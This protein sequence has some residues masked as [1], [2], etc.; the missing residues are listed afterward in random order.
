MW[1]GYRLRAT[2]NRPREA[3]RAWSWPCALAPVD[4]HRGFTYELGRIRLPGQY[5][6]L[7]GAVTAQTGVAT[8]QVPPIIP[9]AARPFDEG[10]PC[11][12]A[13]HAVLSNPVK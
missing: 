9:V 3:S 12:F 13:L 7:A 6:G 11:S 4:V 10:A 5:V 2:K 8:G 1:T